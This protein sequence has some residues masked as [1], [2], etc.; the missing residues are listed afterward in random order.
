MLQT[1]DAESK[2]LISVIMSAYNAEHFL[3]EAI[4]SIL[5]Q[6]YDNFE[7]IIIDDAS[8]DSSKSILRSYSDHRI[9]LHLNKDNSGLTRSL[10]IGLTLAKGAYIA[11]QDADDVSYPERFQKQLDFFRANPGLAIVGAQA[12]YIY[13]DGQLAKGFRISKPLTNTGLQFSLTYDSPFVHS[14]VMFKSEII[15]GKLSG[16]NEQFRTN[17]DFELWSRAAADLSMANMREI[18]LNFRIVKTSVS[19]GYRAED[20]HKLNSIYYTNCLQIGFEKKQADLFVSFLFHFVFRKSLGKRKYRPIPEFLF[21][22]IRKI[23][24]EK[25]GEYDQDEVFYIQTLVFFATRTFSNARVLSLQFLKYAFLLSP[26]VFIS[27]IGKEA[28]VRYKK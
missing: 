9:R 8:T 25:P 26:S 10:N 28:I 12:N 22:H 6:T 21:R 27:V 1:T 11:R 16:Y 4:D 17:Q 15:P 18:L 13:E 19:S 24:I 3:R 20:I 5:N 2:P 14:T 23:A 7:F